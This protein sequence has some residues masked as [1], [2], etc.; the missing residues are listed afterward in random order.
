MVLFFIV[1]LYVSPSCEQVVL[2]PSWVVSSDL[3]WQTDS[4]FQFKFVAASKTGH[5]HLS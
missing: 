5:R 1:S 4:L 2:D 3:I